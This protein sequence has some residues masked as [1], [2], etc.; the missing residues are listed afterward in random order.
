M[1]MHKYEYNI[2]WH[3][4]QLPKA[5]ADRLLFMLHN[6]PKMLI[7]KILIIIGETDPFD[8]LQRNGD[9]PVK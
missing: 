2:I 9:R 4:E 5:D 1:P 7:L 8:P 3:V 6:A